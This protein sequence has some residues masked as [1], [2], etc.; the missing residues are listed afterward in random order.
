MKESLQFSSGIGRLCSVNLV[1]N[2]KELAK[3]STLR[4]PGL[5]SAVSLC[6][7]AQPVCWLRKHL[8]KLP[9]LEEHPLMLRLVALL[10]VCDIPSAPT[11]LPLAHSCSCHEQIFV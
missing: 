8:E 9:A 1:K 3:T 10:P 4:C 6:W 7:G 5:S 11:R 2:C